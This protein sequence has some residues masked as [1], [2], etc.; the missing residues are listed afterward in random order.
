MRGISEERLLDFDPWQ[1]ENQQDLL[2]AILAKCHELNP[3]LPI[4]ENTPKD[5]RLL[6]FYG[7]DSGVMVTGIRRKIK[8]R[9][10]YVFVP[11]GS[12]PFPSDKPTCDRT[13]THYQELPD[14]PV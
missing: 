6:L 11:D 9:R 7:N 2:N 8:T 12:H 5:I 3:W 10:S 13:P 14:D 1:H 4:D